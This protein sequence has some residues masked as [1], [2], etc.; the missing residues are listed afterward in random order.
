MYIY[1][2]SFVFALLSSPSMLPLHNW[3][4]SC[5][6]F[7][8]SHAYYS[9]I[10]LVSFS[11]IL[12]GILYYFYGLVM[13]FLPMCFHAFITLSFIVFKLVF[14]LFLFLNKKGENDRGRNDI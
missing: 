10:I 1:D 3:Y 13:I 7:V 11:C 2:I 4:L 6:I 5:C 9:C 14:I 8:I 12:V